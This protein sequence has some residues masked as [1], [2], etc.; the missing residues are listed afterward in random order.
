MSAPDLERFGKI[1]EELMRIYLAAKPSSALGTG[2]AATNLNP[3]FG[4]RNDAL[5]VYAET[6]KGQFFTRVTRA[7]LDGTLTRPHTPSPDEEAFLRQ[8]GVDIGAVTQ[9]REELG[10]ILERYYRSN[11]PQLK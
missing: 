10:G 9:M 3:I 1:K 6:G 8:Q 11:P 4:M 5:Q 2:G 7:F